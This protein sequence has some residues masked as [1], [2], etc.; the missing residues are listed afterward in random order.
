[1]VSMDEPK[2][3]SSDFPLDSSSF[4]RNTY[5]AHDNKDKIDNPLDSPKPKFQSTKKV[6]YDSSTKPIL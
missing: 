4:T 5:K 6:S 1:M 2:N 3:K